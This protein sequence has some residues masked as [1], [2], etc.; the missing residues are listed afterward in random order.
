MNYNEEI[1]EVITL[2]NMADDGINTTYQRGG[3]SLSVNNGNI[4]ARTPSRRIFKGNNI[5][6]MIADLETR[7]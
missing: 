1:A 6:E 4:I 3:F 7:L 2:L 5:E